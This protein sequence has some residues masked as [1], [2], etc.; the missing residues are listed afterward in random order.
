LKAEPGTG[1]FWNSLNKITETVI[2][3]LQIGLETCGAVGKPLHERG[4]GQLPT[5][6][7]GHI[8]HALDLHAMLQDCRLVCELL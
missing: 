4:R 1:D 3:F 7:T 6:P 5:L 8:G 2:V